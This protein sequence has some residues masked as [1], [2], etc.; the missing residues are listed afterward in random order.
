MTEQQFE[1]ILHQALCPE[2]DGKDTAICAG[3]SRKGIHMNIKHLLKKSCIAAAVILLLTTTVYAAEA[4]SIKTLLSGKASRTY[5]TI[6]QAEAKAGF[7]I[8]SKDHFTNGYAF[9]GAH[10]AETKGLDKDD[11][12]RLTYNEIQVELRNTAGEKLSLT[13]HQSQDAIPDSGLSP[14][15]ARTIGE[16]SVNYRVDHYKFVPADYELT[17]ADSARL[18][19]QGYFISYGAKEVQESDVA[20]LTWE[21]EG[22]CYILMDMDA[23]ETADS[24]FSMAQEL[25]LSGE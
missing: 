23:G 20:F 22:I 3:Q 2:I 21:K 4:L 16:I 8:D 19:Q 10:V 9:A 1:A 17:E 7:E 24:L 12:V 11:N 14:D 13:A 25:I 5:D 6:A 18:Q 15:Q